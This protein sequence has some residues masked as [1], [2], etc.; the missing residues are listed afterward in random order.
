MI[1]V[2]SLEIEMDRLKGELRSCRAQESDLRAQIQHL[3]ATD[4]TMR[5]D[6]QQARHL[7]ELTDTKYVKLMI[8]VVLVVFP[9]I[10]GWNV[11]E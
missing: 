10:S 9:L 4:K 3:N 7:K 8:T 5:N 6:L 11:C 1:C 2:F